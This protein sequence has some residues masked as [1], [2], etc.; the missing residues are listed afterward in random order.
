MNLLPI[1]L[2]LILVI[3]IP[4]G[5]CFAKWKYSIRWRASTL[6]C[7][8]LSWMYFNLWM[9]KLDPPGN[10]FANFVYLV[11]GWL[12]LLPIFGVLFVIFH[13]IESRLLQPIRDKI[14]SWGFTL[15]SAVSVIIVI[16][17]I[18]GRMSEQ[19]AITAAR[20]ELKKRGYDPEGRELPKYDAGHW[21]I[22]YPDTE[23]G[24]IR[25]T[26]NGKMSWIGGL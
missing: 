10:A 9:M 6:I 22:G 11:S 12:W 18:F 17:N 7:A 21:I 8:G 19:R 23:F 24:E 4:L 14:G 16:W 20:H 1:E 13:L 15:C 25:L 3:V 26:R 5:V 2:Y